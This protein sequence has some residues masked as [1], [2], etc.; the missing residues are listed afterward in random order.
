ML[1]N[2]LD[3]DNLRGVLSNLEM[4]PQA[5]QQIMVDEGRDKFA[6]I[7]ATSG[8]IY[9]MRRNLDDSLNFPYQRGCR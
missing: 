9:S 8:L 1:T 3:D 5:N 6:K 4:L 7:A 2:M